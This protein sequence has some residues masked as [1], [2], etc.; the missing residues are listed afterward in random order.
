MNIE[1]YSGPSAA[2]IVRSLQ[3]ENDQLRAENT[4]LQA[5]LEAINLITR[6]WGAGVGPDA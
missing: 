2:D 4:H 1:P 5:A 6:R 3:K